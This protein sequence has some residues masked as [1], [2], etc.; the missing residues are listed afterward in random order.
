MRKKGILLVIIIIMQLLTGCRDATEVT[1]IAIVSGI[2]FDKADDGKIIISL[3]LPVTRSANFGGL[4]GAGST[5]KEATILISEKGHGIMDAYRKIERKLSRKIFLSQTE[6]I[7]IGEKLAREGISDVIEFLF[8]HPESNLRSY[9]FFTEGQASDTLGL[10]SK[11]ERSI[12]EKFVKEEKL[13]AGF[14]TNLKDFINMITEEGTEPIAAQIKLRPLVVNGESK[15]IT[16]GIEGAAVLHKDKLVGWMTAEEARG[17]L[18][19]RNEIKKGII[20]TNISDEKNGGKIG[21]E[22]TKTKTEVNPVLNGDEMEM[23]VKFYIKGKI[24]ENSSTLDLSNP[25]VIHFVERKASD[26]IRKR[27]KLSLEKAQKQLKSDVYGFGTA[28][29]RE[30]PQKWNNYHKERWDEE[31]PMVNVRIV[32]DVSISEIGLSGKNLTSDNEK[33]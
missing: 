29:Y 2:G 3:L 18:W 20:T 4:L 21:I 8:R 9:V 28:V 13:E 6:A 16:S 1:D 10:H 31:F 27:V 33:P 25:E 11:L 23:K 17:A 19:L 30:Y 7:F 14:R 5:T 15:S 24:Y 22:I 26:S 12:V 32:C